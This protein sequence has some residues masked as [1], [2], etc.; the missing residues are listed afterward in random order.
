MKTSTFLMTALSSLCV[1]SSAMVV[2]NGVIWLFAVHMFETI[3]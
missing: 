2:A 3:V 1:A